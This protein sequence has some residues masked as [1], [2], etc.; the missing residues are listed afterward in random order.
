[1]KQIKEKNPNARVMIG[2]APVTEDIA[3]KFGADGFA[4]DASNALKDAINMLTT[5]KKIKDE[6]EST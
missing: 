1:M 5:L 3:D 4:E 6:A 2:G